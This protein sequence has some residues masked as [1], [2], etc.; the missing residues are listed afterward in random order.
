MNFTTQKQNDTLRVTMQG[1]FTFTDNPSFRGIM[2]ELAK[3]EIRQVTLDFAGVDFID[4]AGLGMLLLLRDLCQ[5]RQIQ[6]TLENPQGQVE[7]IFLISKF[8][9]LF[10]IRK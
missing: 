10:T 4:S 6:A 8:D 7:K 5:E 1:Q 9:Q 3:S 2:D